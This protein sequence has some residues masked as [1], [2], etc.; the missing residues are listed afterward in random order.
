MSS[1]LLWYVYGVLPWLKVA[2]VSLAQVHVQKQADAERLWE[3]AKQ[4]K[5][6]MHRF[7]EEQV[8][9]LVAEVENA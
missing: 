4:A 7:D 2:Q 3:T 1:T 9:S 8:E 6:L 5:K